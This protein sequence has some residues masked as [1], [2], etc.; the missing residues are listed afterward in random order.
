MVDFGIKPNYNIYDLKKIISLLRSPGG[1]PWDFEQTHESI[2]RNLLEEAY[3]AAE[4]IDDKDPG[5]LREELGDVLMQV[6]FHADIEEQSGRFTLDDVADEAC[7]KLIRRHPHVFGDASVSNSGDVLV[8]WDNIKRAEKNLTKTS[9]S[10]STVA[11]SLPALWRAEKIQSKAAKAGFAANRQEN[12]PANRTLNRPEDEPANRTLNRTED[13]PA[14][15]TLNRTENE[16]ANRTAMTDPSSWE[17]SA[18]ALRRGLHRLND[19]ITTGNEK[20][21]EAELGDL[22][23]SAVDAARLLDIDPEH[24]LGLAS[25]RF[26][27][28]FSRVEEAAADRGIDFDI[29][30]MPPGESEEM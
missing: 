5:H 17:G 8:N 9:D 3:E 10:M 13:E 20:D 4:A 7:K 23:F 25:D 27:S 1:C 15:R 29:A 22:L 18:E 14:D 11:R 12:E 2:R 16:P 28:R 26:I 21:I 24:A 30:D 19:A 6:V